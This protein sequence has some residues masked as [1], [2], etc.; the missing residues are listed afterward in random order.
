VDVARFVD[1]KREALLAHKTQL[2][3]DGFFLR[4]PPELYRELFARETFQL[5][6]GQPGGQPET[7]L[8]A[9]V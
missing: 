5:V 8:F 9:G 3:K 2:P 6:E 7:D 4:I 1:T